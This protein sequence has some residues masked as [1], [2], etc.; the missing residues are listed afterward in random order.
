MKDHPLFPEKWLDI[1]EIEHIL[2]RIPVVISDVVPV[3]KMIRFA[4]SSGWHLHLIYEKKRTYFR[5]CYKE[6]SWTSSVSYPSYKKAIC[7]AADAFPSVHN[8]VP[9]RYQ[10]FKQNS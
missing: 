6:E 10:P 1:Y 3:A 2:F 5:W 9:I 4:Y 8:M 7:E